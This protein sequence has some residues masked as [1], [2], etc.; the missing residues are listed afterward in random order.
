MQENEEIKKTGKKSE[1]A[2]KTSQKAV[3]SKKEKVEKTKENNTRKNNK[4]KAN[5]AKIKKN[6]SNSIN[7][8]NEKKSTNSENK[9]KKRNSS[10][11][12][13]AKKTDIKGN[14]KKK[15]ESAKKD[16]VKASEKKSDV[17][18]K[19]TKEVKSTT[20]NV[21]KN[22]KKAETKA[23]NS[24]EDA[25]NVKSKDSKEKT[26]KVETKNSKD[27]VKKAE[28]KKSSVKSI[29]TENTLK[30]TID[31]VVV[32][33]KIRDFISKVVAMQEETKK[34]VADEKTK[35]KTSTK[36]SAKKESKTR[37]PKKEYIIEYYDLPYRYNETIVK[38]LAQTPKKLFVYWDISDND[39]NKYI[40]TF[41]ENFFETTY[42]V[43]LLYNEDKQYVKE[44]AINDFANSWYIDIDDPK[45]K[46]T[47]QLG[48]KFKNPIDFSDTN[49]LNENN[50]IL[51]TDY[52]PFAD[53]NLLEVPNDHVL[54]DQLP[55]FL[56][57]R[58]VK[59]NSEIRKDIRSLKDIFGNNYDVREFYE[60]QYKDEL[61]EGM[62]DMD[63]PSSNMTSSMFK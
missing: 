32:I 46:Y 19:V 54:L 9:E 47:I 23:K 25:K 27:T 51:R 40:E 26:K 38:I 34:E 33:E 35:A 1:N 5:N 45:T 61:K 53:S 58:N 10:T 17:K 50:I 52:L 59:T 31:Q 15:K 63:N 3:S 43:L 20:K 14:E 39:I 60:D 22:V 6:T 42:P 11:S 56:V 24:K 13:V 8:T 55:E 57:F 62:F 21:K 12:K 30:N 7:K 16:T 4:S 49:K 29:A 2:K 41:G 37:A 48:R 36:T 44:V 18:D 28:T